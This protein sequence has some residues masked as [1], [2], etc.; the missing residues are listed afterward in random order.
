MH[1][2]ISA[3]GTQGSCFNELTQE[4]YEIMIANLYHF[5]GYEAI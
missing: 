1:K 3:Y 5:D 4:V 2:F